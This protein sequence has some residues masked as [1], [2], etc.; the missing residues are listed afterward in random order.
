MSIQKISDK[1][2]RRQITKDEIDDAVAQVKAKL[3]WRLNE[4]G[5]GC[6]LSRHEILGVVAEEQHELV[7][8]V[9]K[10]GISLVRDELMDIAVACVFAVACIDGKA[11]DW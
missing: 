3:L 6:W 10:C 8:A 5:Y 2:H 7:M 11:V 9:H 1:D 4:K